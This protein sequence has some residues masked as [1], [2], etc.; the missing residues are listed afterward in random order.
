MANSINFADIYQ[1]IDTMSKNKTT[2][3]D[4]NNMPVLDKP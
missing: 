2:G 3:Y 1:E 4:Q